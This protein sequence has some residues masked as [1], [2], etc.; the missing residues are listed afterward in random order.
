MKGYLVKD[1]MTP[2]PVTVANNVTM[3]EAYWLMVN[4][5]I[6]RLLVVDSERLTGIV[7]I[8]DL[9][10]KIPFT[11]FAV[12]AVRANDML[13]RCPIRQIMSFDLITTTPDTSLVDA[14]HL[15]LKNN[16]STLPVMDGNKLVGIITEGDIFRA[17]VQL[18]ENTETK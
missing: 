3:P 11:T 14:A 8:E 2:D 6:K 1:W 4:K 13:A 9:R 5:N 12:D 16:I 17:F 10:Q 7:T 18:F 15:M